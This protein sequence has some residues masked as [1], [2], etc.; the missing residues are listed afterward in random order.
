MTNNYKILSIDE[1]GKA[2]YQHPS[3]LF[4]L[5]AVL[6]PENFKPQLDIKI[7]KIKIKYFNNEEIVFH[8]RGMSRKKGPFSVFKDRKTET[9]FWSELISILNDQK[10]SLIF[11]I[12]NKQ[13]AKKRGWQPK[14]ILKRSYFRLLELFLIQLTKDR[15]RGKIIAESDPSQDPYLIEAHTTQQT[16]NQNY[17]QGVTSISLVSKTNLDPDVQL[18]DALAPIAGMIFSNTKSK[19][20]IEKVKIKLIE[21]KLRD[22]ATPSYLESLL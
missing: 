12:T 21:R 10:I 6:I 5:S 9:N 15:S 22:Q 20:N 17:R 3:K 13:K 18:A 7:R 2:S 8:S 1:S 14:T 4:V 16:Q 11:I 19:N